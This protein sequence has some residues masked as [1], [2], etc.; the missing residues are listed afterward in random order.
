MRRGDFFLAL[1]TSRL[2]LMVTEM[3]LI[4][5]F[6]IL[7]FKVPIAGSWL[8]I[9][10]ISILGFLTFASLGFLAASRTQKIE[11]LNG[12]L[13]LTQIPMWMFSG[14]FFSYQHFPQVF[15]PLI[16]LLPL[17]AL[18]DALRTTILEGSS[19]MMHGREML[20]L[21]L[22]SGLSFLAAL[23]RFQWM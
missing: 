3:V 12:I 14:V 5:T 10:T 8:S 4:L 2:L 23:R 19:P 6:G 17:T 20:T 15:Q 13:T 22:W 9:M 11:T 18:N 16:K 7:L 1:I 21:C